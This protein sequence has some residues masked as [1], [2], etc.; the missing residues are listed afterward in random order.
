MQTV[1]IDG[2]QFAYNYCWENSQAVYYQRL[3]P[4]GLIID[5]RF[6]LKEEK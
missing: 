3:G 5:S 4:T 6:V 1:E 2:E